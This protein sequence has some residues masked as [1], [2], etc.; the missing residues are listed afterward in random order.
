M[1][2]PRCGREAKQGRCPA[3]GVEVGRCAACGARA[4]WPRWVPP[5]VVWWQC[6][7]CGAVAVDGRVFSRNDHTNP[8]PSCPVCKGTLLEPSSGPSPSYRGR[9]FY[10]Y[11]CY[12]CGRGFWRLGDAPFLFFTRLPGGVGVWQGRGLLRGLGWRLRRGRRVLAGLAG[13]LLVPLVLL[14]WYFHTHPQAVSVVRA[15][16]DLPQWGAGGKIP[17]GVAGYLMFRRELRALGTKLDPPPRWDRPFGSAPPQYEVPRPY[18][19]VVLRNPAHHKSPWALVRI[20]QR[21]GLWVPSL[22][23]RVMPTLPG[24]PTPRDRALVYYA[25][26][27]LNRIRL[28]RGL[29]PLRLGHNRAAQR[30]AEDI[31]TRACI[32]HWGSNGLKPYM[33]YTL[34]GGVNYEAE[35]VAVGW[36]TR[37]AVPRRELRAL[38]EALMHSPTHRANTLNPWH[39][40][41]NLGIAL[42]RDSLVLVQQFEGDYIRFT[43][44]PTLEGGVLRLEGRL[45]GGVLEGVALY[46]DPLPH[47]LSCD[48]LESPP[49]SGL[50]DRGKRVVSVLPPPPP[51]VTYGWLGPDYV[52]AGRW[53]ARSDGIFAV[54]ADVSR[55][56]P[57]GP[58]LY[59]VVVTA[60]MGRSERLAVSNYT[61]FP[62]GLGEVLARGYLPGAHSG[63][64]TAGLSG[65]GLL[66]P[67]AGA[68]A[69]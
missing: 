18:P 6:F 35:N 47:P 61:I 5:G 34:A 57:E 46:Y 52:T 32:S 11:R 60:R 1:Q 66:A 58:G 7:H 65:R 3:C 13:L 69:P 9:A 56:L 53:E 30:H 64:V 55:A 49:Y 24:A 16:D 43:H 36:G 28:R 48:R 51:G 25:L 19:T 4:L 50:Y 42:N 29:P 12:D 31:L 17:T 2:C 41:V 27:Q 20:V 62:P 10:P 8:R 67:G 54:E 40:R 14:V 22:R 15:T 21:G 59:T 63:P 44:L 33:R 26:E 39:R 37:W 38:Q 23:A 68:Q 45:L